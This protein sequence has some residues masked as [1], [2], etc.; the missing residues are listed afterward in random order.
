MHRI[1]HKSFVE[2]HKPGKH[3]VNCHLS[4]SVIFKFVVDDDDV[5]AAT[6]AAAVAAIDVSTSQTTRASLPLF[7]DHQSHHIGIWHECC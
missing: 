1:S 4:Q 2:A 7:V 3:I 5:A 6:A